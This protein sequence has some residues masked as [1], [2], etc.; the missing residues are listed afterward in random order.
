MKKQG[1]IFLFY[2]ILLNSC[3]KNVVI[4]EDTPTGLNQKRLL[5]LVNNYRQN[6]CNCGSEYFPPAEPVV[7]NNL[8]ESAAQ[9]HS[10][11]MN[12][13][14]FF[15]HTGSDGN[16]AG[17]RISQA[18]YAWATYGENI[19][20]GY[21]SADDVM[22]GWIKS[23]GHCKNIMNPNFKEMGVALSGSYWTQVFGRKK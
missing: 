21:N 4:E 16:N 7:W 9:A 20:K 6:G 18:G 11:D 19:A 15:D 23:E 3:D 2:I 10:E 17:Y 14:N 12:K 5:E 8:L 22:L 13:N 1:I